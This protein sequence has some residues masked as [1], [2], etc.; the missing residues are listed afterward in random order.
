MSNDRIFLKC[1]HCKKELLLIKYYPSGSY[2][3]PNIQKKLEDFIN[4]HLEDIEHPWSFKP[5]LPKGKDLFVITTES[6]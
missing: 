5:G 1:G 6:D 2:V 3:V 4:D